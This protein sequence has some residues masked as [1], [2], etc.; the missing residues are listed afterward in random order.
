MRH[1]WKILLIAALCGGGCTA[2][3][4]AIEGYDMLDSGLANMD[5]GLGEQAGDDAE[6]EAVVEQKLAEGF[7]E[8]VVKIADDKAAV[9]V[10]TAE[11]IKLLHANR[12]AFAV[13]GKR[14]RN[15][16]GTIT[17]MREITDSLRQL[18][19]LRLGWKSEAVR[20]A[21]ALRA[22][23]EKVRFESVEKGK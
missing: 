16:Q 14:L 17:A 3:E 7:A 8:D 15:L 1:A 12:R 13:K 10:K 2:H 23:L 19:Q 18:Q 6:Q 4:S 20:Y 9:G 5:I 11:F 22:R 21:A